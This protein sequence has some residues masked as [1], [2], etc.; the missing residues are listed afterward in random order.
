MTPQINAAIPAPR[1]V[2]VEQDLRWWT[3][4]APGSLYG[5]ARRRLTPAMAGRSSS[6]HIALTLDDGPDPCSTPRFLDMLAEHDVRAT[7]FLIGERAVRFPG[8]VEQIAADGH[9]I[10]VHG[11]THRGVV[12]IRPDELVRDIRRA[13]AALEELGGVRVGWYR[14]PYGIGTVSS[15]RAAIAADLQ[16]VLW[17]AWGRDW[18]KT[19]SACSIVRTVG[20][21]LRPGGTVLL[22]DTDAYGASGSWRATLAATEALLTHW[23][24]LGWA[25]GPLREH[26]LEARPS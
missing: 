19:A 15:T 8:V 24:D 13:R 22:H 17:T 1:G 16:P 5:T 20:R 21:T 3:Q 9:E 14:P 11:W 25:V 18:S 7:F 4:W 23:T 2:E 26:S 12:R 10:G 6:T